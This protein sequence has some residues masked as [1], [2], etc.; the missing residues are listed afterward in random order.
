VKKIVAFFLTFSVC[1][2]AYSKYDVKSFTLKNG[3]QVFCIEKKT[4]PIIFF[5]VWY[6]CGS[7]C[8]AVSKS[9][10]AHYLEHMAFLTN[11]MEFGNLLEDAGADKDAFTSI[12]T[13][14]FYETVP[15]EMIKTVLFHE[16]ARMISID[17]DDAAFSSEKKAI[18][19]ERSLSI[20]NDPGGA[21]NEC[22]LANVFNR[23]IGGVPVIGWKHEI[24]SITKDDLYKFHS[25]WFAP[26]NAVLVISGDFDFNQ[27]KTLVEEY[28]GKIP[29]KELEEKSEE[30][31]TAS[32][33]KEISY[34]SSKNGNYSAIEYIYSVPFV[35]RKDLRKSIVLDIVIQI[36]NK[37][38]FFVKK[39]LQNISNTAD[40]VEF[41]YLNR[42]FQYDIVKLCMGT[43][44]IDSL[45]EAEDLWK[46]LRHKLI[47]SGISQVELDAMKRKELIA[48]AYR[49]D[50]IEKMSNYWGW[51]L[52]CGYS[53]D[54]IQS[55][56]E[57]IQSISL[58]E[59]NGLLKEVFSQ[60]PIAISKI[61]PKGY[62]RE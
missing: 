38:A 22:L 2:T 35:S 21:K 49:K 31:L 48:L 30:I 54:E 12:N 34:G 52:V 33:F 62:D 51:L 37:S 18:L 61:V 4:V 10:V 39:M 1:G 29:P 59:C 60:D 55:I 6:K 56:D 24:K 58:K 8:D 20:D 43:S 41:S 36:L 26:N 5:S 14:C 44:S 50:D 46:S 25:K 9:G 27:I 42:I 3:L 23:G 17:V 16:A 40:C 32:D 7:K 11:N 19:E 47:H 28:F 57:T 15:K 45:H 13:I 53:P